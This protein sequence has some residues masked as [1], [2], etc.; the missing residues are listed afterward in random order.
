MESHNELK[1]LDERA[2]GE[3]FV[4]WL[5]TK[6]GLKYTFLKRAGE[7]PDLV[8]AL[9][10]STASVGWVEQRD[11]HRYFCWVSLRSTQPTNEKIL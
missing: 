2:V 6:F 1:E 3:R 10:D 9:P 8:Y 7:A 5:N 4:E 11:T